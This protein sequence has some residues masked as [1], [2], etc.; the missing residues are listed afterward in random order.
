MKKGLILEGGAMRG[1]FTAGI[2]DVF[3]HHGITFDG[4]VGVSAGAAFGCNF[5][6]GQ[7]GRTLRYNKKY[8]RDKRY[9]SF[10]SLLTTGDLYGADFCY[11]TLPMEL[12]VFDNDAFSRNPMEF[13][14]VCTDIERG[15]AIYKKCN[16]GVGEDLLWFRAS[17]S[18]PLVSR[19]V[20]IDGGKFLDGGMAD[21][22]PV[23]FFERMGYD[24]NVVILTQPE[25]YLKK[26]N[27]SL[28]LIRVVFKKFPN[29]VKVMENRH[30]VYNE[31]LEYIK[32]REKDGRIFVIR[33]EKSLD[34]G[35]IEH[36]PENLQRVYDNGCEVAKKKITKL[37]EF[38]SE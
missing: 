31:T 8:C 10:H 27:S 28:P 35:H 13:Y 3:M 1:L 6:S 12:D 32:E 16:T 21:S 14:V 26:K 2:L 36:N 30:N 23:K 17:A 11:N 4:M 15:E 37:K 24:K 33:P 25:N 29:L 22:V 9:C 34:I 18:M 20:E 5:K 38:L 19:I 7:I